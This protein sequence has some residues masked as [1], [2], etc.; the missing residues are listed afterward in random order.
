MS[1]SRTL[2]A[3]ILCLALLLAACSREQA[4]ATTP[5]PSPAPSLPSGLPQTEWHLVVIGDSSLWGLGTA[6]AAQIEND[7]GVQV[8]L[9]D[10]ALP[11]LSAGEALA[12]L[13]KEKP[14]Y[15]RLTAKAAEDLRQAEVVVMFFNPLRSVSPE[16]P[17]DLDACFANRAPASC[18]PEG[19]EQ[20]TAD[21]EAIW[22]EILKLR[23]GKPT[24]LRATDIYNPLVSPWREA[25]VFEACTGCWQNMSNAARLAAEAYNIPFL[26]RLDAFN[27][28]SHDEDPREKGYIHFDGEHPS[29]LASQFTAE[30]L[31]QMG[32]E[33]VSVPATATLA[34]ATS[35]SPQPATTAPQATP[36]PDLYPL[37]ERGPYHVSKRAIALEDPRR[38]NRPV[39]ITIWYPALASDGYTG[40]PFPY[41]VSPNLDPDRSGA[42]YPLILSST[43]MAQDLARYLVSH[44]FTWASVDGID[45]YAN[46]N[47]ETIDQPL[48]ILFTLEQVAAHPPEDLAGMIDAERAGAIGYSFDGYNALAMSGARIDPEHYLAQ[49]ADPRSAKP[50]RM[51]AFS[52]G[53]SG[54]WDAFTAH[55]GPAIT[56]SEDGLWQPLTD[57][58]IR[59]VMPM[60]CE[61]WWLF[62]ARGLAAVD[63]PALFLAGTK[64]ELYPENVQIF[65]HLGTPDRAFISFI[66]SNHMMVFEK[67]MIARMA[68]FAT[69]FFGTHLQ[70]REGLAW[71]YSEDFVR[72]QDDLSWGPYAGE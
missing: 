65:E 59:A 50:H 55:A 28:P 14:P 29:D 32:Y 18:S 51:S 4:P 10:Y 61:G 68:H 48:D 45:S 63:R 40:T 66:G 15:T 64:D 62:G 2:S 6:F 1:K 31:S 56:A 35:A 24:I 17:L 49:C 12:D 33:P 22:A 43:T 13:R 57:A 27:G 30:L 53:P 70:G 44:G 54:E 3:Y 42:P 34:Q 37:A 19:F 47:E 11:T 69:A 58:R 46:M 20:Y 36:E 5:G 38:N 7:V 52:C 21:M 72:Q 41:P 39:G 25:G 8:I 23:G 71:Y 26:S 67:K 9:A 16:H 60:A